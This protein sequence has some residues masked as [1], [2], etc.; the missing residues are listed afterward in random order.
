MDVQ[1]F[2]RSIRD[3]TCK[4]KHTRSVT[5]V[6]PCLDAQYKIKFTESRSGQSKLTKFTT[7]SQLILIAF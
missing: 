1:N 3:R 4:C 5:V 2:F 7:K 6:F